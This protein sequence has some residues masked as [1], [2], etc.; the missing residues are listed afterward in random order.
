MLNNKYRRPY[1]SSF[2]LLRSTIL[3]YILL[4]I[5]AINETQETHLPVAYGLQIRSNASKQ[6]ESKQINGKVT[7]DK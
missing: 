7:V 5:L 2:K 6:I 4:Y 3:T 1:T